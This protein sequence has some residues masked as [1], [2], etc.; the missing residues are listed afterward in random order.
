[1]KTIFVEA[2]SFN[3][4]WQSASWQDPFTSEYRD[5]SGEL[6]SSDYRDRSYYHKNDDGSFEP[7]KWF[8]GDITHV[9]IYR[10]YKDP[11]TYEGEYVVVAPYEM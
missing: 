4:R 10:D 7:R 8:A 1:M 6:Y 9:E 3:S 2:E 5:A 11:D